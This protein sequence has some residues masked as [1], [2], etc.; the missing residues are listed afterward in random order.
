MDRNEALAAK[1]ILNESDY[2]EDITQSVVN[3]DDSKAEFIPDISI[4]QEESE[5]R[6]PLSSRHSDSVNNQS[7]SKISN[8]LE[9]ET[10][11]TSQ[12]SSANPLKL[13]IT[14]LYLLPGFIFIFFMLTAIPL[15][16]WPNAVGYLLFTVQMIL[17]Q[18][19]NKRFKIICG[20]V[21]ASST[22][23]ALIDIIHPYVITLQIL[24]LGAFLTYSQRES[25]A[26]GELRAST[27]TEE[28]VDRS[29]E[30][31]QHIIITGA[32]LSVISF[33]VVI[34]QMTL[35]K[36]IFGMLLSPFTI[37]GLPLATGYVLHLRYPSMTDSQGLDP[38]FTYTTSLQEAIRLSIWVLTYDH[39]W[40]SWILLS[41][42]FTFVLEYIIQSN[43]WEKCVD[44]ELW[45][46]VTAREILQQ[47]L[48]EEAVSARKDFIFTNIAIIIAMRE[49]YHMPLQF[50]SNISDGERNE[51]RGPM[52]FPR[53]WIYSMLILYEIFTWSFV[54]GMRTFTKTPSVT[55]WRDD[56][57]RDLAVRFSRYAFLLVF[58]MGSFSYLIEV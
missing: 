5:D 16:Y 54:T 52:D 24:L 55:K 32:I 50:H 41:V 22:I 49:S 51:I 58:L 3:P 53:A 42:F 25:T 23:L 15:D 20:A 37:I 44:V 57:Y 21:A 29:R 19:L 39:D 35:A 46:W 31:N 43:I 2:L 1:Y 27:S 14:K 26:R 9:I 33:F 56:N 12:E 8:A 36:T 40:L 17:D 48:V 11:I 38:L 10:G 28:S 7:G 45:P 30:R 18:N 34:I 4:R 6:Q 13:K 47:R